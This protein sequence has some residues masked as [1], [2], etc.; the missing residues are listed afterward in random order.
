MKKVILFFVMAALAG[1]ATIVGKPTQDVSI[2]SN[3]SGALVKITDEQGA[4]AFSGVTPTKITL[5]KSDGSYFGGKHYNVL[6]T[7]NGYADKS[8]MLYAKPNMWYIAGNIPL[9]GII[10]WLII[11]PL[12]GNMYNLNPSNLNISLS[13]NQK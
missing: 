2:T 8:I 12:N 4:V 11:D 6:I 1:C 10:G 3:P 13:K 7:K 5:D 9:S